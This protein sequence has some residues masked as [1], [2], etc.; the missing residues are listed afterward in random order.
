MNIRKISRSLS[1]CATKFNFARFKAHTA[2]LTRSM[3]YKLPKPVKRPLLLLFA[4]LGLLAYMNFLIRITQSQYLVQLKNWLGTMY[5][6]AVL[7]TNAQIVNLF[8]LLVVVVAIRKLMA[9]VDTQNKKGGS[10]YYSLQSLISIAYLGVT[11]LAILPFFI[12][13]TW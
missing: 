13:F 12:P 6:Q 1:R 3:V 4:V 8:L 5:Q 2:R 11:V 7:N 9:P 10:V